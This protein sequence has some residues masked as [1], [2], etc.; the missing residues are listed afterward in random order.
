MAGEVIGVNTAIAGQ[1]QNI[2]FAVA[3]TPAQRLIEELSGGQVPVHPLLGV[4]STPPTDGRGGAEIV[5]ISPASGAEAAGL[6]V[7][8]VIAAVDGQ[9]VDSPTELAAAIARHAPGDS[10]TLT[11]ERNAS[12]TTVVAVL[13]ARPELD[14]LG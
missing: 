4:S 9:A 12:T 3:I 11:V 8:D 10:I 1:A 6:Q 2:G 5:E 13:G 14:S 7:G